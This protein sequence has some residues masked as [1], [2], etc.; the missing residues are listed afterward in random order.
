MLL[1][2][3]V[4]ASAQATRPARPAANPAFAPVQ[5]DPA[6]PRV[7]LIGDSISIGYTVPT[8]ERLAGKANVHRPGVNCGPTTRGVENL[9]KWLGDTKWDVIHFN[10][11][12]HDLKYVDDA[13]KNASPQK[14]HQMVPPE[15]Y[16]KNLEQMVVRMKQTGATL[17]FATTTPVPS[18]EPQRVHDDAV[19]YNEIARRVMDRNGV[20]IDDLHAFCLPR[21]KEIQ[22]PANVHFTGEG[23]VALAGEVAK[24]IEA[25]LP[26][27]NA[28]APSSAPQPSA[29]TKPVPVVDGIVQP[30]RPLPAAIADAMRFLKKADGEYV[31]GRID[32]PLAGYFSS[33]HV[34]EDGS[35]S[36][37]KFCF[38]ARQHA[39]FIYTFLLYH[40]YSGEDEWLARARDLADWNLARS[41]PADAV[42]ASLPWSVWTDGKPGGSQDKDSLEPDKAAFL[43]RAYLSL[44]DVTSEERY[45]KG[46]KAIA[47][48]LAKRQNEDGSW[49]FR[50]VPQDGTVRQPVGGAPVFFV[51]FFEKMLSYGDEPSYRKAYDQALKL[52]IDRNVKRNAWGTYHE[53]IRE[54]PETH[55]S[56]E[57]MSFTA[58]YL[59]RR[60]KEHPEYVE[61][62]KTILARMEEKLVHTDGHSAAPAPAVSEQSTF[63][64]MMPGHT[65][66]YC[67]ALTDLHLATGD[68]EAKR[69]A[70]SGFNALTYMQSRPGLFRT[71][72]Q[73]VNERKPER[74][75]EDWYSQHL[76]TVC[77]VLEAMPSLPELGGK[78]K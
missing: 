32:G 43:G 27:A 17:I 66:R 69:K 42:W 39:Y 13:G 26:A 15:E 59:F 16:E 14:G 74:K 75:R 30:R 63:Q 50:V 71:M 4:R 8:R 21:L 5:D 61:M 67:L 18:G 6:L 7:L 65:A 10:F 64:H 36:A 35:R 31:P 3:G 38:P 68:A 70:L 72:F 56:A 76:Y 29:A 2:F 52:M 48:T 40:R 28:A 44:F 23:Y 62:G 19:K 46:A 57:P 78:Q 11:G 34:L 55:L 53:D 1:A 54:R 45:L 51:E 37:R 58:S 33:A 77:H 20:R 22:L 47:D 25:A 73:L 60:A 24:Q 12:L 41:T 49:P 9:D